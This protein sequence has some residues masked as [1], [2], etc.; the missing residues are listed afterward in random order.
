[1]IYGICNLGI[2]P[3]RLEKE[4]ASEM[5]N[6]VLFGEV[7]KV[8][9]QQKKWSKI[10]LAHDGY[11]GWID[12]KQYTEITEEDYKANAKSTPTVNADLLEVLSNTED[13]SLIPI[14]LGST[15]TNYNEGKC[16]VNGQ[17]FQFQGLYATG[18]KDKTNIVNTA[19]MYLNA[20]YLW[21]GRTPF[22]IDC[23]GFTQMVYRLNGVALKRDA[24]QQAEQGETLSFI[25]EATP[26]DLAFFDNAEGKIIHVGIILENNRIIHA[27]GKVRIDMLDQQGVFNVDTRLHSH[28]LRL[29][30]HLKV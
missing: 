21:G 25:E 19:Y 11:E 28:K 24:Y 10:R 3:M 29:I 20:P 13:S 14:P 4:D 15:L 18:K 23:S 27:H 9:D 26:G 5:I 22:G 8:I 12:N 30:K 7:F 6:Q 16:Q 1:M 2:V 17:T